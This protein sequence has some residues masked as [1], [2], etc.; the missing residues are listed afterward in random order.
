MASPFFIPPDGIKEKLFEASYKK[1]VFFLTR[2]SITGGRKDTKKEI[3]N[4]DFQVIE[5]LGLR[6]PIFTLTALVAGRDGDQGYKEMRDK[7]LDALQE[8]GRGQLIHPFYGPINNVVAR[9]FTITENISNVGT[10]TFTIVFEISNTLG[11]PQE[12]AAVLGTIATAALEAQDDLENELAVDWDVTA[13]FIGNFLDAVGKV[14][15]FIDAIKAVA[16]IAVQVTDAINQFSAFVAEMAADLAELIAT[17]ARL[18]ESIRGAFASLNGLLQ[19][20]GAIFDAM[21]GMFDFGD[22]DIKFSTDTAGQKQRQKNRD[23]LNSM[24]QGQALAEAYVAAAQLDLPTVEDIDETSIILENQFQKIL[25]AD[26][27]DRDSLDSLIKTRIATTSFFNAQ[28]AIKPRRVTI[29]THTIPARVL[30]YSYY[31]TSEQG[32]TIAELNSIR[33]DAFVE[34]DIEILSS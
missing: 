3:V 7:L 13:G 25:A 16:A 31:G 14:L 1:A 12:Q 28:R 23:L 4:S 33:D 27:I 6:Q 30:A 32:T 22:L 21:K 26:A 11:D 17:P 19:T 24:V 29:S 2:S 10:A 15:R 5:D 18:A 9:S 20:P 34:G 8:G